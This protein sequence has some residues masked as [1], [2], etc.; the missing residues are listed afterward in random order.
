MRI[1][2]SCAECLYKRQKNK[3]D[4]TE[5]LAEIKA[6]LDNRKETD[7]SPYM[8]YLFNKV[9]VR[10]FGKGA[11][12]S[13]IKKQYNDLVLAMED[14]LRHEIN[15]AEEP[16]A[17]AMMMSRAGN[18]IDFGAMNSVDRDEFLSLFSNTE[19]RE[20]DRKTYESFLRECTDAK[21]FLLIC[22]NCGEIVLDKLMLE[23]LKLR[24]PHLTVRA[25][26]RGD[27]VLNDAT[28]ED[29]KYVGLDAEAEIISNG[30]AVAGT[31]YEMLPDEAKNVLDNSDMILAKGQGNYESLSGQ[32]R[33]IFY[34]FLCKCELFTS[35]FNV[36][37][38]TGIF[39]E[40]K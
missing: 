15:S 18:Y 19:M 31:I 11:D 13:V 10:Y 14:S 3:T 5:Y 8:V 37:K 16:L 21:T 32:G 17:K 12:Y 34:E 38:L 9:H 24:F 36:P 6:L 33:H 27:N 1:S 40:E 7:T 2:Q 29:A 22:D 28:A 25:M 26:V 20:D 39:I 23:Q 4:N 30:E 35:R